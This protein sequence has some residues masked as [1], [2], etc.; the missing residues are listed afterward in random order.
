MYRD[1]RRSMIV[2]QGWRWAYF[3]STNDIF[4]GKLCLETIRHKIDFEKTIIFIT[5]KRTFHKC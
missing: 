1:L 4:R 5:N 3:F 2:E